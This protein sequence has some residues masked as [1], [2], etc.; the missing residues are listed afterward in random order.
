MAIKIVVTGGSGLLGKSLS[1]IHKEWKFLSSKDID[2]T[3]K[4]E[5]HE[6]FDEMKCDRIIHMAAKVGGIKENSIKSYDFLETNNLINSNVISW[7]VNTNTPITFIS[8]TCV[9]PKNPISYPMTEDM[10]F[11]GEP[12]ETNDGY[13]YAKRFA[14]SMLRSAA[15]QYGL[16]YSVLYLCNLYGEH[17]HFD[18]EEKIHLVTALIKKFHH[19]KV[20]NLDCVELLGTGNPKRQFMYAKDA[21]KVISDIV[22]NDI[23][24][25]Y[26]VSVDE[27]LTVKEIAD[28][29]REVIGYKGLTR[30]NGSLDGVL[31]KDVSTK[32]LKE[33]LDP[34]DLTSLANGVR[35]TYKKYLVSHLIICLFS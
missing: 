15:K 27:N 9:Y 28:I 31:R 21:A 2:L 6:F 8:S 11:S 35:I 10:V 18:D 29:V 4:I 32:K 23:C 12:E 1:P 19:A 13:A 14:T 22:K 7:C 16:K 25:E 20:N 30:Y 33:I 34:L 26:N 5:T 24:G 3:N 17:D